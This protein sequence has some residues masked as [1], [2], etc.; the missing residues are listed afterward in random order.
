MIRKKQPAVETVQ[1]K[2][3]RPLNYSQYVLNKAH[4]AF[5]TPIGRNGIAQTRKN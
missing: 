2:K 5:N 1:E 3:E 4:I